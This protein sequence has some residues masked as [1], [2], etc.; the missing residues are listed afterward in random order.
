ML[1]VYKTGFSDFLGKIKCLVM[2]IKWK[3]LKKKNIILYVYYLTLVKNEIIN[4][5][6]MF[7]FGFF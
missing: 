1:I 7:G 5:I 3:R 2:Q 4:E 6:C